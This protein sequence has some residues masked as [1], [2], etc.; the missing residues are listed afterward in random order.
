MHTST[1]RRE[2]SGRWRHRGRVHAD[3]EVGVVGHAFERRLQRRWT[4]SPCERSGDRF[5]VPFRP[6]LPASIQ[7]GLRSRGARTRRGTTFI[8]EV[9]VE[10]EVRDGAFPA[11]D[12]LHPQQ[13]EQGIRRG[14]VDRRGQHRDPDA[15]LLQP[16]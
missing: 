3:D 10:R 14:G 13:V 11:R 15:E 5:R 16:Q 9:R 8:V 1:P 4:V 7:Q 12:V 2:R 6:E